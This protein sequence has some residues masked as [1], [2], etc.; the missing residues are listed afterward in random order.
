MSPDGRYRLDSLDDSEFVR[1]FTLGQLWGRVD[2]D[3]AGMVVPERSVE[4]VTRTAEAH[5]CAVSTRGVGG[6]WVLVEVGRR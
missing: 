1:G 2:L 4:T 6:G 3:A 5:G